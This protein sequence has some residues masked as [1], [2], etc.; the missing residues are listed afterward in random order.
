MNIERKKYILLLI[1]FVG[2]IN[3]Q[4]KTNKP[5]KS[6]NPNNKKKKKKLGLSCN[7]RILDSYLLKGRK[8]AKSDQNYV[9]PG[10]KK[11]CCTKLDQQKIYH[12]VK[13]IIPG[14]IKEYEAKMKLAFAKLKKF[15][16]I[17]V[18]KK[19]NFTGRS[20]RKLFCARKWRELKNFKYN[21]FN[22]Q[23]IRASENVRYDMNEIYESFFC[24][25][26]DGEKHAAFDVFNKKVMV[27]SLYCKEVLNTHRK[28]ILVFNT[29]LVSYLQRVQHVVDCHH[30]LKSYNLMFYE[31]EKVELS[32][33]LKV[34]INKINSKKFLKSCKDVC[35]TISLSKIN[36]VIEGDFDFIMDAVNIFD[37]MINNRE[38]GNYISYK[39]RTFFQS[40]VV[41]RKLRLSVDNKK[42]FIKKLKEI[43]KKEAE[44]NLL[45]FQKEGQEEFDKDQ[46]E[47]STAEHQ[48]GLENTLPGQDSELP[49]RELTLIS[50]QNKQLYAEKGIFAAQKD[51]KLGEGRILAEIKKVK[52]KRGF[53][54]KKLNLAKL[55]YDREL[56]HF[57]KEIHLTP[58]KVRGYIFY[59]P[60]I[61]VDINKFQKIWLVGGIN[62]LDYKGATNFHLEHSKF[63]HMLF[64]YRKSDKNDPDLLYFLTEFNKKNR[65]NMIGNL[66]KP[67]ELLMPRMKFKKRVLEGKKIMMSENEENKKFK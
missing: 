15:H 57:Y 27:N 25:L 30:Y 38:K 44:R 14:R 29:L 51:L 18:K 50:N 65:L 26:C 7:K 49:E 39:M 64:K 9:C 2:L 63:Y 20:K 67:F 11:N 19:P 60:K 62:P 13:D 66:R 36:T 32:N 17:V 35:D 47:I 59:Y 28:E 41:P 5:A 55:V 10:I 40:F 21:K 45:E 23:L 56:E 4:A 52:K 58:T 6:S 12:V 54:K 46:N 22:V 61:P 8:F 48:S 42:E 16:K 31:P 3:T 34:C 1:I 43:N 53:Q 33:T 24:I 37:K